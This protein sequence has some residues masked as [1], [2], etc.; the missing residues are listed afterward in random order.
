MACVDRIKQ[1]EE[2][3]KKLKKECEENEYLVHDNAKW[4]KR[5]EEKITEIKKLKSD[6]AFEKAM[7]DNVSAEY[8]SQVNIIE[9]LKEEIKELRKNWE[10]YHR[11][12]CQ[13]RDEIEKCKEVN[14]ELSEE[15]EK[16]K[17]EN[18]SLHLEIEEIKD[19]GELSY[20]E[21]LLYD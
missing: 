6:L 12:N 7:L 18:I 14:W 9:R 16:L 15:N 5:C 13:L 8:K 20:E 3:N 4:M 10:Y 11:D 2:E 1:L 19:D 21:K 17:K